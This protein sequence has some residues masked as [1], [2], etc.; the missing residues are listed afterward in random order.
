MVHEEEHLRALV[1]PHG[2]V[3]AGRK[4]GDVLTRDELQNQQR[5]ELEK[6]VRNLHAVRDQKGAVC[7]EFNAQIT[8][9]TQAVDSLLD[10]MA[11]GVTPLFDK[12]GGPAIRLAESE[13]E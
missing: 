8:Q 2:T 1:A 5:E 13:Q 4:D 7:K 12:S 6:L 3:P 10:D 9:L 11:I